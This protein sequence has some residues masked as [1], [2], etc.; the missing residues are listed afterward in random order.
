MT[1][2][3]NEDILGNI[4]YSYLYHNNEDYS[5][6]YFDLK[7]LEKAI[8]MNKLFDPEFYKVPIKIMYICYKK[9]FNFIILTRY[10]G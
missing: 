2:I 1:N 3:I 7:I 8:R 10:Q 9:I 5:N 4:K 6:N